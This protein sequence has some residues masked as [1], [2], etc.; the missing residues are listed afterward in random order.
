MSRV[1]F[2]TGSSRGLGRN[3]VTAVLDCGANVVA[4]ARDPSQLQDLVEQF[5]E[6]L[7]P[8][9]LDVTDPAAA[10][11]A[12]EQAVARFGRI[13]VLVNNAGYANVAA[14]EDM[15]DDDFHRQI[16]T[17]FFGVVNVTRAVLPQ[18]HRQKAGRILQISSIGGRMATPGLS[19]YHAAKWAIS[20][21]SD[22]LAQEVAGFGIHVTVVQP[23]GMRTDWSGS[24]M[25]VHTVSSDYKD[26]VGLL[27]NHLR[28]MEPQSDPARVAQVIL[29]L[30][31]EAE[32]PLH[33]ALGSDA[34]FF[35]RRLARDR[36]AEDEKWSALS[37]S[38]DAAGTSDFSQ[39]P[40][41]QHLTRADPLLS[42]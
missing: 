13:D 38:T 24:S 34:L 36:I 3:I 41:G 15:A 16:D 31:K 30:V 11:A 42:Q 8:L 20:G 6:R 35:A 27:A 21:F 12:A 32:P 17:N 23:G 1:W 14:F 7:L 4:T 2:I 40:M 25:T 5:G 9:A 28:A 26:S 18:M 19:P 39:T 10:H 29:Q 37:L 22:A 33:I